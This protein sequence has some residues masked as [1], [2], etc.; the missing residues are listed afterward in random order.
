MF[1]VKNSQV[2]VLKVHAE[3]RYKQ[4]LCEK[5]AAQYNADNKIGNE[6]FTK[7]ILTNYTTARY[8][9][10]ATKRQVE[11]FIDYT[12]KHEELNKPVP[13]GAELH[14]MLRSPKSMPTQKFQMLHQFFS[15]E[16]KPKT[17]T[18]V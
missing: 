14:R 5:K 8:Y 18:N 7:R 6:D 13:L 17:V 1:I 3:A 2:A 4:L 12:F 15:S 11:L 16:I 9:G 10:F